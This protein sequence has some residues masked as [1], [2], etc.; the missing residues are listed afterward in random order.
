MAKITLQLTLM[1]PQPTLVSA[2]TPQQLAS[3]ESL[4]LHIQAPPTNT[5]NVYIGDTSANI[6]AGNCHILGPGES[7][8]I[9]TDDSAADEDKVILDSSDLWFDG[10]S[11][12]DKL[13]VAYLN[14]KSISYNNA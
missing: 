6:L 9:G 5:G 11:T 14:F 12:G 2:G 1:N 7:M 10:S 3:V 13:V 4:Y 8:Q